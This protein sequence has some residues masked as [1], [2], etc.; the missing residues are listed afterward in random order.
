MKLIVNKSGPDL[1]CQESRDASAL[2]NEA[3]ASKYNLIK[4]TN[5]MLISES[6]ADLL[7][8]AHRKV[9]ITLN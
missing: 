8:P 3:F 1:I 9:T 4:T 5:D 7:N 6:I 2:V